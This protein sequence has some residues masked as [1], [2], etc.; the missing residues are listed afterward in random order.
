MSEEQATQPPPSILESLTTWVKTTDRAYLIGG[1][2]AILGIFLA[3]WPLLR[4]L[5]AIWFGLGSWEFRNSDGYFSHGVLVPLISGYIIVRKWDDI[6]EF[7]VKPGWIGIGFLLV[8]L[9]GL[10][11][12]HLSDLH[13]LRS[14]FLIGTM[15]SLVW[16]VA[17]FRWMLALAPAI[18]YLLFALPIWTG[19]IDNYTNPLQIHSTTV[20]YHLLNLG[21]YNVFK[22]GPTDLLLDTFQLSVA[23]PCSGL[24]LVVA[25]T[26]FTVFFVLI[27]KLKWWGNLLM[28][29]SILPLCLFIN[30]LRIAL[31]GVVGEEAGHSAGL[32]FHDY[33]GYLT[34]LV[35]FFILFKFAK[36]LGWKD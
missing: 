21:G 27:A 36:V 30:G 13:Q 5:P 26:A 33:S 6:K 32:Q 9:L 1:G 19:F 10:R 3:F 29:G 7:P 17:G 28:I 31:I 11:A 4:D 16:I 18:L 24:K 12:A 25:V 23:V 14:V 2:I 34:L 35:C 20:A 15:V 8:F 22:D